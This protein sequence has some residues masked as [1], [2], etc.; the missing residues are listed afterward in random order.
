[1]YPDLAKIAPG[2]LA[3]IQNKLLNSSEKD[4]Y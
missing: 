3:H 2:A 4:K 1:M